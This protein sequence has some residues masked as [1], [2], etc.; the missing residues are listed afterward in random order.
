M[1]QTQLI[2]FDNDAKACYNRLVMSYALHRSQQLVMPKSATTLFGTLL[3]AAQYHIKTSTHVPEK[4]Y[5][6]WIQPGSMDWDK[7]AE[8]LQQPGHASAQQS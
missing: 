2:S 4:H 7:A 1:T 5:S 8:H 3:Q 6:V